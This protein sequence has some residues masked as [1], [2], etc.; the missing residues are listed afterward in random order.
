MKNKLRFSLTFLSVVLLVILM[1]VGVSADTELYY[2]EGSIRYFG[3]ADSGI[4]QTA[5]S[6]TAALPP[7]LVDYVI[8]KHREGA[9][10]IPIYEAGF[11]VSFRLHTDIGYART[12]EAPDLFYVSNSYSYSYAA[13]GDNVYL[14]SIYPEYLYSG[15]ELARAK[16][17]YNEMIGHI[18]SGA[19]HLESDLEKIIFYH[20]Y[21]V[22]NFEYDS[23]YTI[24]DAYN[25]LR[26]KKGVCQGYTLLLTELLG[27]DGIENTAVISQGLNHVWNA[28]RL[29]G[30]WYLCD[31][32][33]DDPLY[34]VE[35]RVFHSYLLRSDTPF[36]HT[37]S[38]GSR[39]WEVIGESI[40]SYAQTYDEAFWHTAENNVIHVYDGYAYS[41]IYSDGR[42]LVC[43]TDLCDMSA[44]MLFDIS[45]DRYHS[46]GFCGYGDKLYYVESTG[47]GTSYI[48]EYNIDT[49][50]KSVIYYYTHTCTD[51]CDV[52][53]MHNIFYLFSDANTLYCYE[54]A[55]SYSS[56]GILWQLTVDE[57]AHYTLYDCDRDGVITNADITALVR[58]LS[59]WDAESFV[60]RAADVNFDGKLNNRDVIAFIRYIS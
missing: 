55:A 22:S 4:T 28:V 24:Y 49:Q 51:S 36:G 13:V 60:F 43:R 6:G 31:L 23:S 2:A 14:Y 29:D 40:L 58:V 20:D 52:Y 57:Y 48:C 46:L 54:A 27:R 5:A 11:R 53:C 10:E 19:E 18:T 41:S 25:M 15:D 32:T 34:D 45:R 17:E 30:L 56:E 16:A 12:Y 35:G 44:Q 7:E 21:I 59:G 26:Y 39:D 33:W 47:F 50:K 8:E 42:Y 1:S 3:D 37:L 9:E 38:D